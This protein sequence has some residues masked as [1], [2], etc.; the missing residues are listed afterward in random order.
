MSIWGRVASKASI[1]PIVGGI[2]KATKGMPLLPKI[3][4]LS[5][6]AVFGATVST[7]K[8]LGKLGLWSGRGIFNYATKH[9]IRATGAGIALATTFGVGKGMYEG[10]RM[11]QPQPPSYTRLQPLSGPGYSAWASRGGRRMDSTH[12]GATGDL[13][14]ALRKR[15]HGG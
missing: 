8:G 6:G 13:T 5:A 2:W 14:L 11:L 15:R 7:G 4:S 10:G 3:T 1:K 12:L 9:P